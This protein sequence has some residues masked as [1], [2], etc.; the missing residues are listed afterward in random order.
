M[1]GSLVQRIES[2]PPTPE[3]INTGSPAQAFH[4]HDL[5]NSSRKIQ[6]PSKYLQ[7]KSDQ[8]KITQK[9]TQTL[10][11]LLMYEGC[12]NDNIK[13]DCRNILYLIKVDQKSCC[14]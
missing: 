7:I 14:L 5:M 2:S 10:K 6:N 11:V 1:S 12:C 8:L 13:L 9:D 3:Q 4:N